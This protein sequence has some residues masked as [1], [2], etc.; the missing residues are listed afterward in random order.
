MTTAQGGCG[1]I[2]GVPS[3]PLAAR[4]ARPEGTVIRVNGAT[5]GG[6]DFAV[7]AGPCSIE[8]EGQIMA[9]AEAVARAGCRILRGG[10]FKPRTSPYSFQG[11]GR[12]GLRLIRKAADA[13]GLAVVT[14]VMDCDD[15]ADIAAVA[16]ILQ[17]GSR[18]M[19]SYAFL[20]KVG[21]MKKPVLLKRNMGARLEEF[22]LA[23]EYLLMEGTTEVILCE[24]GI[25]SF[26]PTM[27]RNTMDLAA[28]PLLK[29][30]SH[31][32]VVVDPSHGTGRS[33]LVHPVAM[34]AMAVGA[35]GLL[36]EI[37][38]DPD[39]ALCDGRQSLDFDRF[40]ALVDELRATHAFL[41]EYRSRG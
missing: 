26:D 24:R 25:V 35:D 5:L 34:G 27:T 40:T 14:E 13:H 33:E 28:V 15:I 11:L 29:L 31:L 30:L 41:R 2:G 16:D 3:Y 10:A 23:A 6:G 18:T 7:M 37:H 19:M 32:P 12:E 9:C 21:R 17:V 1:A 38:P 36:V 8:D 39:A 4:E 20:R 22:L